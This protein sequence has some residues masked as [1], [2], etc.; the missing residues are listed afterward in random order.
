MKDSLV[1]ELPENTKELQKMKKKSIEVDRGHT[2]LHDWTPSL[3]TTAFI[4]D[5]LG[6]VDDTTFAEFKKKSILG[7]DEADIQT[8]LK[9][10]L[11][12][13]TPYYCISN[14]SVPPNSN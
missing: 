13:P 7:K 5:E 1:G 8:V 14:Q 3:L 2:F 6:N 9:D 4:P 11:Q 12:N 10:T